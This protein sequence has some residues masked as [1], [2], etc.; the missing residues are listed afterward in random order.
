MRGT[1]DAR[2]DSVS[3]LV[4]ARS[5]CSIELACVAE[6]TLGLGCIRILHRVSAIQPC[7]SVVGAID[8]RHDQPCSC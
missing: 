6:T 2:F 1:S 4:R 7:K 3:L 8:E 5:M